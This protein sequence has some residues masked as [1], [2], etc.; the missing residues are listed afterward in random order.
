MSIEVRHLHVSYGEREILSG[1]SFNCL[2]NEITAIVG[3]NGAGKTTLMNCLAGI[4][5]FSGEINFNGRD[6]NEFSIAELAKVR[7]VLPQQ[8]HLNFP[9]KVA[10]VIRL[11]MFMSAISF[12]QQEQIIEQCLR[13]VDAWQFAEKNYL[14]LSGGEKQRVQ[15]ARVLAQVH[16]NQKQI[17]RYLLLDEP[18]SALD[19][20]HQYATLKMLNELRFDNIGAL[21]IVHDL[22]LASLYCD[23]VIL[24]H[25]GQLL[26]HGT[27]NQVFQTACINDAFNIDVAINTHPDKD[28]PFL[29][30]RLR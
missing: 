15:L 11:A 18:T 28:K 2:P 4:S 6:V 24:L 21:I 30:P 27:P 1:I 14:K 8:S 29:I 22:N 20:A 7:A 10:E 3:E 26:K 17:A 5:D 9:F 23:K 16:A 25:Q 12:T 19:L 13:R